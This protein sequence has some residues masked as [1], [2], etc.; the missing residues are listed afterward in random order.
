MMSA[1]GSLRTPS[2]GP[3]SSSAL[4]ESVATPLPAS[5]I[6]A[7]KGREFDAVLLVLEAPRGNQPSI[8]LDWE[9]HES[10][11]SLRVF[12]VGASRAKK[13]LSVACPPKSASRLNSI[14]KLHG[15]KADWIVETSVNG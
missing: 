8:L 9:Q 6:H 1:Y 5:H 4:A 15:I 14:L 12:Y 10:T 2:D 13:M 7:V 3:C 11:E